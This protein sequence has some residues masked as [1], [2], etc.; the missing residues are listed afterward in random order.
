MSVQTW[1]YI[2]IDDQFQKFF[3]F[4]LQWTKRFRKTYCLT[5]CNVKNIKN[6]LVSGLCSVLCCWSNLLVFIS[7]ASSNQRIWFTHWGHEILNVLMLQAQDQHH[8]YL[9][10]QRHKSTTS[11]LTRLLNIFQIADLSYFIRSLILMFH[12]ECSSTFTTHHIHYYCRSSVWVCLSSLQTKQKLVLVVTISVVCGACFCIINYSVPAPWPPRPDDSWSLSGL[13]VPCRSFTGV[14]SPGL[15]RAW[16][17][18]G[19]RGEDELLPTKRNLTWLVLVCCDECWLLR[20]YIFSSHLRS[21]A[22]SLKLTGL[23][24]SSLYFYL[25]TELMNN[26]DWK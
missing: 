5:Q 14:P 3:E 2:N 15:G 4:H 21:L 10:L 25:K 1:H 23:C 13:L 18:W 17:W 8:L 24:M 9:F 22:V 16:W 19:G 11:A 7:T 20:R 26:S 12:D 6:S